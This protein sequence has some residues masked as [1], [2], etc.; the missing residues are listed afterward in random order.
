[1]SQQGPRMELVEF[2][3]HVRAADVLKLNPSVFSMCSLM[4]EHFQINFSIAI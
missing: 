3:T 1:M 4:L 2:H